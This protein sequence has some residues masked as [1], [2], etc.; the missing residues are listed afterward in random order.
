M[1][2]ILH[3]NI[4]FFITS[5]AVVALAIALLIVLY[6]VIAILREV[7]AITASVR[8]ASDNLEQDVERFR[9]E[10]KKGGARL[11]NIANTFVSFAMGRLSK[12]PARRTSARKRPENGQSGTGDEE[13]V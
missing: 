3:A 6:Y 11:V 7:R 10:V 5:V 1:N 9:Q 12:P 8:K 13:S 4:F 2:D